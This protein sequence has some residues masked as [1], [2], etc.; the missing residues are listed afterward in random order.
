[1]RREISTKD[2][3][4]F[5]SGID[6]NKILLENSYTMIR[7]EEAES[8]LTSAFV[9][10]FHIIEGMKYLFVSFTGEV[11]IEPGLK[12]KLHE[13][14]NDKTALLKLL[15]GEVFGTENERKEKAEEE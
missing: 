3:I 4:K 15:I 10:L 1:M 12:Q 6:K 11:K 13:T 5:V 9:E 14:A 2:E 7:A 8:R